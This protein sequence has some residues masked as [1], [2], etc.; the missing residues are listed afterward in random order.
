MKSALGYSI[1]KAVMAPM[2]VGT[3]L[4]MSSFLYTNIPSSFAAISTL[5]AATFPPPIMEQLK[6]IPS[7]AIQIPNTKNLTSANSSSSSSSNS[8]FN[9]AVVSI[10]AGMTVIWFNNDNIYHT[11]TTIS[12]TTYSPPEK[13]DSGPIPGYLPGGG[14]FGNGALGG[15]YIHTFSKPGIYAYEDTQHPS[16]H[17]QIIVGNEMVKGKNMAMQFPGQSIPFNP[18]NPSRVVLRFIPT[19]MSVPP[20]LALT[21]NVTVVDSHGKPMFNQMFDDSDGILDLELVPMKS[22]TSSSNSSSNANSTTSTSSSSN[23]NNS[24]FISW[25]PDFIGQEAFRTTGAFH[26]QGPIMVK[27]ALYGLKVAIVARDHS[28]LSPPASDVFALPAK[29]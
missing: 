11:V 6:N 9:P 19:T 1:V 13:F 29:K 15:S 10:P 3:L 26:I 24:S 20:V 2:L 14:Y 16:N 8:Y 5:K 12:N 18:N 7:Y 27:D 4:I 22:N 28:I 21:Y 17:G 25:G 23:S